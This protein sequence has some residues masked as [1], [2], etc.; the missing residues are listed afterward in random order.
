MQEVALSNITWDKDLWPRKKLNAAQVEAFTSLYQDDGADALPPLLVWP[1]ADEP[2]CYVLL[3]G[4]HRCEAAEQA[5]LPTLPAELFA[6]SDRFAA[7]CEAVRLSSTGPVQMT[8]QE[9]RDAVDRIVGTAP[10]MTNRE[11]ARIV[12]V[13]HTFV[14]RRRDQ[15]DIE[16]AARPAGTARASSKAEATEAPEQQIGQFLNIFYGLPE[17][18]PGE[19][20]AELMAEQARDLFGDH[21]AEWLDNISETASSAAALVE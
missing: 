21:A 16:Q 4:W 18:M 15:E 17:D 20:L 2:G 3:D 13:S 6:G 12:G 1:D 7:Y 8:Q 5:G 11:I 14:N 10:G 9:K 19:Q